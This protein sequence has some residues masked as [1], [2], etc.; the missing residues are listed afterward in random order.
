MS[1]IQ[2]EKPRRILAVY[3][4]PDDAEIWAGGTLLAHKAHGDRIV[5]CILTH[6]DGPRAV[7]AQAGAAALGAELIQFPLP[8]RAVRDSEDA[9]GLVAEV[10]RRLRPTIVL[11]HWALDSHP[12]HEATWRI[13]RGAILRGEAERTLQALY[14]SDTYNGAGLHGDFEPDCLVDVTPYW[15]AKIAALNAHVSQ[16]PPHY[17]EMIGRQ[18]GLHGARS[19]VRVAEGFRRAPFLGKGRRAGRLLAD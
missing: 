5:V 18:C 2:E 16:N 15:E 7:E 13:T 12:D 9:V 6:G 10:M 8:D 11:T 14:W 3:A 19:G 17:V 1:K 4:H